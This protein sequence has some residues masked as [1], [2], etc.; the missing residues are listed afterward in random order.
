MKLHQTSTV[1]HLH[2]KNITKHDSSQIKLKP[3]PKTQ[4][5]LSLKN[6]RRRKGKENGAKYKMHSW[7]EVGVQA[8]SDVSGSL[9]FRTSDLELVD[10]TGDSMRLSYCENLTF[11]FIFGAQKSCVPVKVSLQFLSLF[12]VSSVFLFIIEQVMPWWG[13]MFL[14]LMIGQE[15]VQ[16]SPSAPAVG[17]SVFYLFLYVS[18]ISWCF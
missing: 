2:N 10:W 16:S 5:C 12:T 13:W 4:R 1:W 18:C 6:Q 11:P 14:T 15:V 8:E 3:A 17:F 7:C 9:R